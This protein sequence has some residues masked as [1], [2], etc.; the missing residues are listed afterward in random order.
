MRNPISIRYCLIRATAVALGAILLLSGTSKIY[1]PYDFLSAVYEYELF[2]RDSG[3]VV[4]YYVPWLEVV[5]GCSLLTRL[6]GCGAAIL[7]TALFTGFLFV[8]VSAAVA[9]LRIPCGCGV[10]DV[11]TRTIGVPEVFQ[12]VVLFSASFVVLADTL[13]S[14]AESRVNDIGAPSNHKK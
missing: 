13:F 3:F 8:R 11:L 6:W 5:V 2:G 14:K 4:A 12:S 7:A 1:N 9:D 10:P